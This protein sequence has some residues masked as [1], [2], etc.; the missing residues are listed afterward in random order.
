MFVYKVIN[1]PILHTTIHH[2]P[3]AKWC[4]CSFLLPSDMIYCSISKHGMSMSATAVNM[5]SVVS[6]TL[7]RIEP[8]ARTLNIYLFVLLIVIFAAKQCF[9][10][11][12]F[13]AFELYNFFRQEWKVLRFSTAM[14]FTTGFTSSSIGT[15]SILNLV[16]V[17][18]CGYIYNMRQR[19]DLISL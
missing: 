6:L 12:F 18:S 11:D 9:V 19:S 14:S 13:C 4:N 5:S 8:N 15:H 2:S 3:C 7:R 17:P 10:C 1:K 16:I